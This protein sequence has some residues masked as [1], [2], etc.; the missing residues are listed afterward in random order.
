MKCRSLPISALELNS[1]KKMNDKSIKLLRSFVLKWPD[2]LEFDEL[3]GK[4]VSKHSEE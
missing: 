3:N 1:R 2:F 4:L